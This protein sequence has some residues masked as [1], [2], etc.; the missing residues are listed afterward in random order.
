MFAEA[1]GAELDCTFKLESVLALRT[2][3]DGTLEGARDAAGVLPERRCLDNACVD[4]PEL[5]ASM[6]VDSSA[7]IRGDKSGGLKEDRSTGIRDAIWVERD[8]PGEGV[9][10]YG[11]VTGGRK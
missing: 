2:V 4:T 10:R 5:S 7:G 9:R 6:I 1:R 11:C 3:T 8:G